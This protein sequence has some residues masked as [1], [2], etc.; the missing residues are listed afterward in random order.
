MN[1]LNTYPR[2]IGRHQV[3]AAVRALMPPRPLEEHEARFIAERQA[4]RLLELLDLSGPI[5]DLGPVA[6]L[7][8]LDVRVQAGL[9]VSGFSEWSR[10]RWVIA[11]NED[12]HPTRRRFTLAH[13]LKHVL[14]NPFI[15]VLYP[16][17]EGKPSG[18]RAEAICDYFAACLLMPRPAVKAAWADGHQRVD[19]LAAHFGVSRAAMGLRLHQLGL[20][21]T[22]R[23]CRGFP[24][25]RYERAGIT[26]SF[27]MR[28]APKLKAW[29]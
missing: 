3:I 7:P 22:R 1:N 20:T 23:R 16:G 12:D 19:D 17:R 9:P 10:S 15:E 27:A 4:H 8:R 26:P 28:S 11:L 13:E 2:E 6:S 5:T 25:V 29:T 24:Q 21:S 14:D 18:K